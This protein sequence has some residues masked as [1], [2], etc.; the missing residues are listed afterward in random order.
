[1]SPVD[2]AMIVNRPHPTFD[3]AI[4]GISQEPSAIRR[5]VPAVSLTSM[6]VLMKRV[7]TGKQIILTGT[8]R[9]VLDFVVALNAS[10]KG[11]GRPR[12]ILAIPLEGRACNDKCLREGSFASTTARQHVKNSIS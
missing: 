6:D 3:D 11:S 5:S 10:R 9:P 2:G 4:T 7:M 8:A 12:K 1:M